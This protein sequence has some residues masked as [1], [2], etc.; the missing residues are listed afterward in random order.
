M[1]VCAWN[2]CLQ[3]NKPCLG[4]VFEKYAFLGLGPSNVVREGL[5]LDFLNPWDGGEVVEQRTDWIIRQLSIVS[6]KR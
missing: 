2:Y 1:M 4:G 5:H 6:T 3:P